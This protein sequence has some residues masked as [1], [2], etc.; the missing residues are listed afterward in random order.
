M[1]PQALFW[2]GGILL[3]FLVS[4][5]VFLVLGQRQT[6][7]L[8]G[9]LTLLNTA[10]QTLTALVTN[11]QT[12]MIGTEHAVPLNIALQTVLVQELTHFHTPAVDA[13]LA[14]LGPPFALTE[15][16]EA[17]LLEAM[18]QREHD[19]GDMISE[20]ERDAAHMLPFIIKRIKRE[21]HAMTPTTTVV[22]QVVS[23]PTPSPEAPT[24]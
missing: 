2:L 5:T 12:H 24:S 22:L 15:E 18:Q 17:E 4:A 6:L 10:Q 1:P 23:T 11:L 8:Q 13:L 14:K 9:E 7:R 3:F 19:M 21:Q 20:N 16:E